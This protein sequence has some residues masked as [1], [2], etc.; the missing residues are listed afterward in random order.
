MTYNKNGTD[1]TKELTSIGEEDIKTLTAKRKA[2][3]FTLFAMIGFVALFAVGLP[4][5]PVLMILPKA[6]YT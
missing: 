3:R 2:N 6:L 1:S 4:W 5:Q